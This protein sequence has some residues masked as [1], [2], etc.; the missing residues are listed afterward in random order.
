MAPKT[1][2][3]TLSAKQKA[4][5]DAYLSHGKATRAALEAGYSAHSID[6][7]GYNLLKQ[8]TVLDYLK[9]HKVEASQIA[10][11]SRERV[12]TGLLKIAESKSSEISPGD[13]IKAWG[14]LQKF[15]GPTHIF[16]PPAV[17]APKAEVAPPVKEEPP[18]PQPPSGSLEAFLS[19]AKH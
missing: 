10:G 7:A 2:N 18:A 19:G 14:L 5:A 16:R 3:R 1:R 12:I 9:L 4:F 17:D 6:K 8:A 13:K 11:L 15:L